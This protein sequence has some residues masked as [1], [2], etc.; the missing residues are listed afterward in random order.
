MKMAK[1]DPVGQDANRLRPEILA[2]V[3][4]E[5]WSEA[6]KLSVRATFQTACNICD[7]SGIPVP[8]PSN[9]SLLELSRCLRDACERHLTTVDDDFRVAI[10]RDAFDTI[11]TCQAVLQEPS[12]NLP[13]DEIVARLLLLGG[14]LGH[15]DVMLGLVTT[16]IWKDYGEAV[17]WRQNIGGHLRERVPEWESAF[18]PIAVAYCVGKQSVSLGELRRRAQSWASAERA[19]GNNPGLPATDK[20]I[21]AGLKR[22]ESNHRLTIPGRTRG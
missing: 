7:T 15:A 12:G 5:A 1:P 18:L 20:G 11:A 19:A 17:F 3:G 21:D 16:G 8:T 13:P 22:M 2:A 9:T 14:Q 6:I 4:R 10:A